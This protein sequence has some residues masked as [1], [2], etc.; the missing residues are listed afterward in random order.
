MEFSIKQTLTQGIL[1]LLLVMVMAFTIAA[2]FTPINY[3]WVVFFFLAA[4]PAQ[5]IIGILWQNDLPFIKGLDQKPQPFKGVVL[6]LISAL[7]GFAIGS[8]A[9]LILAKGNWILSPQLSHYMIIAIIVTIWLAVVVNFWPFIG[10]VKNIAGVGFFTLILAYVLA[11]L[12]WTLFFNYENVADLAPWYHEVL[13]PKGIFNFVSAI[14]FII[15]CCPII[16]YLAL[17]DSWILDRWTGGKQPFKAIINTI[18]VLLIT[19][20]FQYFFIDIL[21]MD[22]MVYM[23]LVPICMVFG[24]FLVNNM[25]QF[26]LFEKTPQPLKGLYKVIIATSMGLLM[27]AIYYNL[28]PYITGQDLVAGKT[29]NYQLDLWIADTMLGISFPLILV[30]TGFLNFWLIK[31]R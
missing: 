17:F 29:G 12:V 25:T 24:V 31:K 2:I 28:S 11:Y 9:I 20:V 15:S 7:F 27:Y 4:T 3:Q 8:L 19:F 10:K 13:D 1:A 16:L 22:M 18:L 14:V 26:L 6:T 30:V 5:I 23:V 21:E